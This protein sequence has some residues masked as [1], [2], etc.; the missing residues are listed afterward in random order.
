MTT[1]I[2]IAGCT[3]RVGKLL[4][5]ELQSGAYKNLE[6]AGGT[7][8]Q[9]GGQEFDF[10]VTDNPEDLFKKS[11]MV[12]DFT[13]PEATRTHL[14]LAV[15]H[16]VALLIATTGLKTADEDK[17]KKAS[18]SLPII[19]SANTSI[20]VNMLDA[21]VEKTAKALGVEFDVEIVEAHHKHKV[22]A[23]SGTALMLGK[24]AAKA[25]RQDFV[26]NAVLAREGHTGPRETGQIGISTVRG[27]D[28]AGEHTVYFFGEGERLELKQQATDRKLYATGAL[29][30]AAWLAD[31]DKGLYSMRD[32]LGL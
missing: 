15:K 27:G 28:V 3:G 16:G 32:V 9:M 8:R 31:K 4:I 13:T 12:I 24:T 23:P 10:F 21:L 20:A 18:A 30:G 2:G 22:D 14:E 11:D 7:V 1:K 6:L 26:A 17:I 5:A 25:R 19:Y 29:K